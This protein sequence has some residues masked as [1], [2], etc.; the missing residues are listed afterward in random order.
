MSSELSTPQVVD[1]RTFQAEVDRLRLRE[2]AHKKEGD[3]I[4]ASRRRLPRSVAASEGLE[5][6][7][8]AY[9]QN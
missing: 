1:R 3:A 9:L 4:A 8:V 5:R 6:C 2:K 7:Q